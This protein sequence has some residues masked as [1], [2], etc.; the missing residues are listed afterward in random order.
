MNATIPEILEELRLNR[1][2][3]P[4]R[5][6]EAAVA[7]RDEIVP[8]LL[9]VL[10]EAIAQPE[11]LL[12]DTAVMSHIY[13]LYLLAQFREPAAYE[14]VVRFFRT[15]GET[16]VDATGDVATE[17][18]DRI[19]AALHH[20]DL[21]TNHELI[22]DAAASQWARGAAVRALQ[23]SVFS[24]QLSRDEAVS[25]L[26]PLFRGR[27]EREPSNV[28]NCLVSVATDLHATELAADVRRAFEEELVDAY[29][30]SPHEVEETLQEPWELVLE[31]SRRRSKGLILDTVREMSWWA[32]FDQK[33]RRRERPPSDLQ[34]IR[35]AE[36]K[37]GRN[38]PCPCG[39]GKKYKKCCGSRAGNSPTL[40]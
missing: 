20:G 26:A 35:R 2:R 9:H 30:I 15:P 22:E 17:S 21:R 25:L 4:R 39:S 3:F 19:L 6:L 31:R 11:G 28:W 37:V 24:D 38:E 36:L 5:A 27:I 1:G 16:A 10:D 29:F 18:L 13:A 33:G 34:T 40:C 32:C 7:K 14:R 12:A 23:E 8:E